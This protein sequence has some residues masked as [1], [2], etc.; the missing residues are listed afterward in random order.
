MK[1]YLALLFAGTLCAQDVAV[2]ITGTG[3][4]SST[5]SAALNYKSA[6]V[7]F[8]LGS[9]T[10]DGVG[11]VSLPISI[12]NKTGQLPAGLQFDVAYSAADIT[13][14]VVSLGPAAIAAQ[15]TLN[16]APQTSTPPSVRCIIS[17]INT[18]LIQNGVIAN[19]AMQTSMTS[20]AT[21]TAAL[22]GTVAASV[23]ANAIKTA[24]TA[25]GGVITMPALLVAASCA[26]PDI[27][28]GLV[29]PCNVSI[30]KPAPAGGLVI[31]LASDSLLVEVP[32]SVQIAAGATTVAFSA[33][34][35]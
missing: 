20:Q 29:V 24:V 2:K 31:A 17:G 9:G 10:I 26:Q 35:K 21:T 13:S 23:G 7:T 1:W 5:S 30:N 25:G 3:Q 18:T 11:A 32:A 34:G 16:C 27:W 15:K 12:T 19:V 6:L 22:L 4:R 14:V 33:T 8:S 28:E